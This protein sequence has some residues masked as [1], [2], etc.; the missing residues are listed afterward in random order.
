MARASASDVRLVLD[1][2]P[3]DAVHAA[4]IAADRI[5]TEQ[6]PGGA[7]VSEGTL[8]EIERYLAAHIVAAA[9]LPIGVQSMGLGGE[10]DNYGA[11]GYTAA[12][13]TL[14]TTRHGQ[15][16]ILLDPTSTLGHLGK[17][18]PHFAVL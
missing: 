10:Q 17:L 13:S 1:E 11:P 2:D 18:K 16:A 5:M 4:L 3:G 7:G 12:L 8:K 6:F 15:I 9:H 14:S